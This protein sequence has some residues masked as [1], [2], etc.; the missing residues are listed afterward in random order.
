MN[1]KSRDILKI[2]DNLNI[3]KIKTIYL[4]IKAVLIEI[5]SFNCNIC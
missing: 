1:K 2:I 4:Q 3:D 5:K